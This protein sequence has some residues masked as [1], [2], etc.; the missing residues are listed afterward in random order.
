MPALSVPEV[1]LLHVARNPA[2]K[3]E[4]ADRALLMVVG[5]QFDF[6]VAVKTIDMLHDRGLI[7]KNK[8]P[9]YELSSEGY[10]AMWEW[11][12]AVEK[13]TNKIKYGAMP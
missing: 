10:E 6:M 5:D 9:T 8:D 13:I 4:L 7:H 12:N 11:M 1:V 2:S 3:T